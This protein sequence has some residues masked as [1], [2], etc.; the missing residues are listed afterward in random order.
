MTDKMEGH[1]EAIIYIRAMKSLQEILEVAT[2]FEKTARDFYRDLIPRVSENIRPLVEELAEEE[3]EHFDLF[4]E[5]LSHPNVEEEL[6]QRIQVPLED[7]RF[8]DYVHL[9]SLGDFPDDQEILLYAMGREDAA[10]KQYRELADETGPGEIHDLL[11]FLANE[12]SKHKRE[13]ED[14]YEELMNRGESDSE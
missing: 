6:K 11:V 4:A 1:S 10:M 13:L 3:Q 14:I 8:S 9:P 12:E 7:H 5:L 2:I